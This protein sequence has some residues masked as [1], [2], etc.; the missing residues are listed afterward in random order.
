M[1]DNSLSPPKKPE[2]STRGVLGELWA[3]HGGGFYNSQKFLTGP[4]GEP[5]AQ[6]LHW[7]KWEAYTTWL[8]GMGLLAI[9]YWHG[10]K[11]YLIDS[12][13]MALSPSAAITLSIACIAAGWLV[14]D[15]LCRV[16]AGRENLLAFAVLLLVM[17][18][19]WALFHVFGARAAYVHVGAVIGTIMVGNVFF[20]IIPGQKKM[21]DAIRAGREPDAA[22]GRIGKQ[23]S[24]HNTYFTLPVLFVMISNHY[25]MTYRH[26]S[27]WLVLGVIML[28]GVLIRRSSHGRGH[29][30]PGRDA[31]VGRL[32][33][34]VPPSH[35]DR[36]LV[37]GRVGGDEGALVVAIGEHPRQRRGGRRG[38]VW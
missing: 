14:Y 6:D 29:R 34:L 17:G 32:A 9:I 21:V 11:T 3:V 7:S 16:L 30:G 5:L 26:P 4:K 28:A 37:G 1:L 19:A 18:A 33:R 2:D 22:H 35:R 27:G 38:G 15:L 25:P 12:S 23:R 8:S 10:A 20:R 13:V 24:V 36:D 31:H